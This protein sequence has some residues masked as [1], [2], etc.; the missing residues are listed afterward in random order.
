MRWLRAAIGGLAVAA[1]VLPATPAAAGG[2]DAARGYALVTDPSATSPV[3]PASQSFNSTGGSVEVRR[4]QTG[5][6]SVVFH[7][8]ATAGGVA[9][10][11]AYGQGA[12][13]FCTVAG[14]GPGAGG[15]QRVNVHCFTGVGGPADTRFTVH[16]TGGAALGG[17]AARFS[18]FWADE[19][20]PSGRRTLTHGYTFDSTGG[21][22]WYERISK[23]RYRFNLPP[24]PTEVWP[25]FPAVQVT[26]YHNGP[27]H[28]QIAAPDRW[29][30]RC[31]NSLGTPVDSRFVVT[32]A[33]G[34][35]VLGRAG[36]TFHDG[37]G[38][39]Q[40][41]AGAWSVPMDSYSSTPGVRL[42]A[43]PNGLPGEYV[44]RVPRAGAG[45]GHAVAAAMRR[46][47]TDSPPGDGRVGDW[48][49]HDGDAYVEVN[50]YAY[51]GGPKDM[52]FRVSFLH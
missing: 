27:V 1:M 17:A 26:A 14:W 3:L 50:C 20:V 45:R 51:G 2:G 52:H 5:R 39:P 19:P 10:A 13:T 35:D 43:T 37:A 18:Y 36:G 33:R 7:G 44:V 47:D 11:V 49:S 42:T 9:H 24:S 48:W 38:Y 40:G 29:E 15:V 46:A 12:R 4:I 8:A 22:I 34:A 32:Y 30:V 41:G 6:Y 21:A 31:V 16:F 25:H 28:C 23:G